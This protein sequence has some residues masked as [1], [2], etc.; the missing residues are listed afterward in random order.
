MG[1]MSA[2]AFRSPR[3]FLRV[4]AA[5]PYM[6]SASTTASY[7]YSYIS[8]ITVAASHPAAF[9]SAIYPAIGDLPW[10]FRQGG[11]LVAFSVS[12]S[13]SVPVLFLFLFL[14][15]FPPSFFVFCPIVV[16]PSRFQTRRALS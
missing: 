15:L 11:F 13:V 14:F 10:L 4:V 2:A 12:V 16:S 5:H 9:K 7:S 6:Y 8:N 1:S 3:A